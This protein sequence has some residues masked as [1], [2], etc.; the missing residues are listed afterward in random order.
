[1]ILPEKVLQVLIKAWTGAPGHCFS[2]EIPKGR[3][4]A[5]IKNNLGCLRMRVPRRI[6]AQAPK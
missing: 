6:T 1:V 3:S 5:K 2:S 4:Q